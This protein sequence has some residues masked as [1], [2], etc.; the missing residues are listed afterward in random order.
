MTPILA[1]FSF[2]D[3]MSSGNEPP[4][5]VISTS[6]YGPALTEG[7]RLRWFSDASSPYAREY[8]RMEGLR[9]KRKE[10]GIIEEEQVVD[11]EAEN[12]RIVAKARSRV[13]LEMKK[14]EQEKAEREE[15]AFIIKLLNED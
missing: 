3:G 4:P 7:E 10:L 13:A 2:Y 15:L 6:F 9:K 5:P 14:L 11:E 8:R 1:L 12:E